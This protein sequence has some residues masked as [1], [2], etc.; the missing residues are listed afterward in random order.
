[1]TAT[2]NSSQQGKGRERGGG[3]DR[4]EEGGGKAV[5]FNLDLGAAGLRLEQIGERRGK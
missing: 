5:G 2:Q 4:R 1:V 3:G